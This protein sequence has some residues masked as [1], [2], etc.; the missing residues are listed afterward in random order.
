MLYVLPVGD[1]SVNL[2]PMVQKQQHLLYTK[3]R[4]MFNT[5]RCLNANAAVYDNAN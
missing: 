5:Y 4:V 1:K 3:I 2:M